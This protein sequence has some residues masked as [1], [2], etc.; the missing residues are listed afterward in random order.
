MKYYL[1]VVPALLVSITA[2]MT[3]PHTPL[4]NVNIPLNDDF[5]VGFE[6]GI[7]LRK[8]PEMTEEYKCPKGEIKIEEF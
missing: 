3:L 5:L 8:T 1:Y 6:T 7:F 2:K 4:D